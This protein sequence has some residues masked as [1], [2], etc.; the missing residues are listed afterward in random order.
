MR[1]LEEGALLSRLAGR[2]AEACV[3]CAGLGLC[4]LCVPSVLAGILVLATALVVAAW[5]GVPAGPFVR[6]LLGASL[7]ASVSLVPLSVALDVHAL[8]LGFDPDGCRTGIVAGVRAIGT[9]SATLLLSGAVPFHRTVGLLRRIGIPALAVDLLSLVHREIFLLDEIFGRLRQALAA[10][11][12]WASARS[13]RHGLAMALGA[14]LPR[15]LA[16]AEGLEQGL[17]SRGSADG[18]VLFLEE[19]LRISLLGIAGA[20]L[21]PALVAGLAWWGGRRLGF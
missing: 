15:A 18:D 13:S 7:F 11:G 10:R 3:L 5:A 17:A 21:L 19:P 2:P 8:R 12:G 9:L 6:T 20:V 14:L 4:A 1:S 16:R